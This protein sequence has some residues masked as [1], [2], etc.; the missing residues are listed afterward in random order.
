MKRKS[1]ETRLI[2]PEVKGGWTYVTPP[3]PSAEF[4]GVR[5]NIPVRA[6]VDGVQADGTLMPLG[7]GTH[8]LPVRAEIRKTIGKEGGDMVKVVLEMKE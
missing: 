5:G 6:T 3:F 7:D 4:F 2:K 8:M 1:F